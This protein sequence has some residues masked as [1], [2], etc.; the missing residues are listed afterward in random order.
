MT[1]AA[2]V[3]VGTQLILQANGAS[4]SGIQ[5]QG[6]GQ[7][8]SVASKSLSCATSPKPMCLLVGIDNATPI[9][10]GPVAEGVTSASMPV[11]VAP[12]GTAVP[13]VVVV[14]PQSLKVN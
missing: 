14:P 13:I 3:L 12:D 11:A 8:S 9:S 10:D 1:P 4:I 2:L 6:D 7:N 5:W